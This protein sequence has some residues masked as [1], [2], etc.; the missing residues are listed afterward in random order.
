MDDQVERDTYHAAEV[1]NALS[2]QEA[3]EHLKFF[4]HMS[5]RGEFLEARSLFMLCVIK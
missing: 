5:R 3:V 2:L 4:P 1:C